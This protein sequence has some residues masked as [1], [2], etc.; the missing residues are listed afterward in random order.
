MEFLVRAATM[1]LAV[2]AS[3]FTVE[4]APRAQAK[5]V[6]AMTQ[7][8]FTPAPQEVVFKCE[9]PGSVVIVRVL[10]APEEPKSDPFMEWVRGTQKGSKPVANVPWYTRTEEFTLP[11]FDETAGV[12]EAIFAP[13]PDL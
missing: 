4:D 5:P 13:A 7:A 8:S 1:A 12:L 11:T 3:V 6:P 2:L 9:K 10:T